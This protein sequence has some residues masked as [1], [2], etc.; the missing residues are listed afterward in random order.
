MIRLHPFQRRAVAATH[1]KLR[2]HQSTLIVMPTGTGKTLTFASILKDR[3]DAGRAMVLAHREELIA[4]AAQKIGMVSGLEC[5]IEMASQWA[6]SSF[7]SWMCPVIVSSI[8]TQ[9]SGRNGNGRMTRFT[10]SEFGTVVADEAH[11]CTSSSWRKAIDHYRSN[12]NLKLLGVTATP[13]RHDEEAL[14]QIFE[15]VAFN[16][17]LSD[18]VNDGW[19]S[20]IYQSIMPIEGLDLSDCKT[21]AGDLN[22][23]DLA[24][25]ME[26]EKPLLALANAIWR[27]STGRKTLVFAASVEHARML[28]GIFNTDYE[29]G[30]ARFV[31]GK[32]PRDQRRELFH[33]Y[34]YGGFR[35][36]VNCAIATE[37]FDEP[38][39]EVVV[40][41]P[42]KSL[43]LFVQMIGRATRTLPGVLD[44]REWDDDQ[45]ELGLEGE[46]DCAALRKRLIAESAKPYC[47]VL[48][49]YC[50]SGK[51]RLVNTLDALG[52][53]YSDE[54]LA[55]AAKHVGDKAEDAGERLKRAEAEIRREAEIRLE[56]Q[57]VAANARYSKQMVNALDYY[58]IPPTMREYGWDKGRRPTAKMLDFLDRRGIDGSKFTYNQASAVIGKCKSKP[59]EKQ[60]RVLQRN[61]ISTDCTMEE[62]SACIDLIS[63][64]GWRRPEYDVLA[65]V[66]QQKEAV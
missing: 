62:A 43:P 6:D 31:S 56:R 57:R 36:L 16:Y 9:I 18:A 2:E 64:N 23:G 13:N 53:K 58:D 17:G 32:T 55:R 1:E 12:P 60:A 46:Q 14:G 34:K 40:P 20:P 54:V 41:K 27:E 28:C 22:Q 38:S 42:T 63:A 52:G 48:D 39:I 4:Q 33:D 35:I 61:G 47:E 66:R 15:S 29:S 45:K 8:Q 5:D 44:S 65:K 30:C 7:R 3:A 51:H 26:R 25:D 49:L 59:T 37:G 19:L 11:H 10:P 24:R 21:T 50:Q